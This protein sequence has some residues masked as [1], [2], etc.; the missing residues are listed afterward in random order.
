MK[1]NAGIRNCTRV[2]HLLARRS[3]TQ[4]LNAALIE[5][6]M[7]PCPGRSRLACSTGGRY[8]EYGEIL[9]ALTESELAW[10]IAVGKMREI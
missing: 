6:I 2:L 3:T 4:P 8:E 10:Q 5:C 1:P 9:L 7:E